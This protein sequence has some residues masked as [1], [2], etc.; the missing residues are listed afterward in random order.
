MVSCQDI[1]TQW[2]D[3]GV[4]R[5]SLAITDP[6]A[7][8]AS[9]AV[10][11]VLSI[12]V[13]E[14]GQDGRIPESILKALPSLE[15]I[16]CFNDSLVSLP[17]LPIPS[18]KTLMLIGT[19]I[20]ELPANLGDL[21]PSIEEITIEEGTVRAV[22]TSIC[23]LSSLRSLSLGGHQ[24]V[25]PLDAT[26][27]RLQASL[28]SLNLGGNPVADVPESFASPDGIAFTAL[29]PS[30]V[31]TCT[32]CKQQARTRVYGAVRSLCLLAV[33]GGH[34]SHRLALRFH[35]CSEGCLSKIS[36]AV[37]GPGADC[38]LNGRPTLYSLV[39]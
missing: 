19:R 14:L 15:E 17:S 10:P 31:G 27:I 25:T 30:A 37:D 35:V 4:E 3:A 32:I 12:T 9:G 36:E 20:T 1:I 5:V 23:R 21:Y 39:V 38:E 16:Q 24:I 8:D 6:V 2:R 18:L 7:D 11:Q 33:G 34:T 29:E 22:P 28:S 13:D 26:F